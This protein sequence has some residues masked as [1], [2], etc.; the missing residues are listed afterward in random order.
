M[1]WETLPTWFWVI[2]YL[3]LLTTLG[4]SIY[5]IIIKRMKV[6]SIITI[7]IAITVPIISLVNS[8]GRQEGINEFEH[9]I[10]HLMQ[11]SFWSIY[12]SCGYL[13]FFVWWFLFL[14]K[15]KVKNQVKTSN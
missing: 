4:S 2:Y 13:F 15:G 5:S 12:T 11:G 3:F 14:Y 8:I 9:L 7:I 10:S 6:L 1:Y